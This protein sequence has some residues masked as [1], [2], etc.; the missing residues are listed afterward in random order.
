MA[1]YENTGKQLAHGCLRDVIRSGAERLDWTLD[2]LFAR[3]PDAMW[4][5]EESVNKEMAAMQA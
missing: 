2:D 3:T 1:A 5:C 4:S